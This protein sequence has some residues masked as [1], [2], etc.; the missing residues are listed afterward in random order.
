M[1]EPA[2]FRELSPEEFELLAPEAKRAY[3]TQALETRSKPES[4]APDQPPSAP[5]E[6][7]ADVPPV[8]T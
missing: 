6:Q 3:L 5:A 4:P 2:S 8:K 1:S 7:P